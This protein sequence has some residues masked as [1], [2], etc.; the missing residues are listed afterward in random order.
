[1]ISEMEIRRSNETNG[2]IFLDPEQK[3]PRAQDFE[4][5][6]SA[7]IIGQDRAVRQLSSLYQIFLAG[8]NPLNRPI[9]TMLFL[10]PTGSGKTRVVEAAAEVLFGD[11]N[12]VIK[13]DC[14]EFQHSH[15][16][17]KLIG[18]PPG[19]I[20]HRETSAMLSQENLDR[21][22]TDDL[23]LSIV[24]FDEIEKASDSLWQ[25][26][27]GILDKAT[28]TLG[29]NRRVDF[30]RTMVI[31][32]S[33]LGAREMEELVS[34]GIGFA[35]GNGANRRDDSDVDQKIYRTAV[36][37]ARRK[38]SPEFMNRIDKVVVF[39]S[40]KE[41]HL[42]E[43][44]DIELQAVQGR[45]MNS[46][47]TKFQFQCSDSVKDRLLWE[48]LDPR[49]GARHLKRSVERLLVSPL[50]NLVA[51]EQVG[52]GDLIYIDLSPETGRFAF[53]KR[54]GSSSVCDAA[55]L[56]AEPEK[57]EPPY[58]GVGILLPQKTQAASIFCS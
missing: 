23:K 42:R 41:D 45:V 7:R 58:G 51:S 11:A 38:F 50:S 12:Q 56:T 33:N 40:L 48:G 22:H 10:G 25:L 49:Y 14:A 17:A 54:P 27:L 8:M 57:D 5:R 2:T 6:L 28:L 36:E 47:G 16:I 9:G 26:L 19:Y 4:R 53:S 43:I 32:T 20:G 18:S 46:A 3:S 52:F 1:M 29:D 31:L 55:D 37:A 30:S 21:M 44:L 15:E 35:P 24:L 13:I 34:G 39:R